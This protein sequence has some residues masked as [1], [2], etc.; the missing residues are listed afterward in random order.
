MKKHLFY[1]N[2]I[3][4]ICIALLGPTAGAALDGFSVEEVTE[5]ER[6]WCFSH[7][8]IKRLNKEPEKKPF[9]DFI[10]NEDGYFAVVFRESLLKLD[11]NDVL[12]Y[13][14]NGDFVYGY[15]FHAN[16]GYKDVLW[17]HDNIF[18][19]IVGASSVL[20]SPSGEILDVVKIPSDVE[21]KRNY[22]DLKT[23]QRKAK[24]DGITIEPKTGVGI[25]GLFSN[26]YSQVVVTDPS[27][28]TTVVYDTSEKLF[29]SL[30]IR[31]AVILSAICLVF[32]RLAKEFKR[33][34]DEKEAMIQRRRS[35]ADS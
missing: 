5:D 33:L 6:Q 18:I 29:R 26:H 16:N 27:G 9:D 11:T 4:L 31:Y 35:S 1:S 10:V 14:S 3:L 30:L 17:D 13:D 15:T 21:N 7:L 28:N 22:R 2:I 20:L 23:E 8:N 12:V 24:I 34:A 25:I 32:W 19:C